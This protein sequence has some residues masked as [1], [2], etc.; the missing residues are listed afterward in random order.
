[1]P[2]SCIRIEEQRLPFPIYA[3]VH[4]RDG[5]KFEFLGTPE[6]F[7]ISPE[8]K[9]TEHWLGAYVDDLQRDIESKFGVQLPGT[10]HQ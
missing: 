7:V 3:D 9:I 6:T 8:G 5:G 2:V 1:M 10:G 4:P